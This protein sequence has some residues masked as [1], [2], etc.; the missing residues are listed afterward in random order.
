VR[1]IELV[2]A[3][4]VLIEQQVWVLEVEQEVQQGLPQQGEQQ[5]GEQLILEGEQQAHKHLEQTVEHNNQFLQQQVQH[6]CSLALLCSWWLEQFV[7]LIHHTV[8]WQL[9]IQQVKD[10]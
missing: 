8:P 5:Q 10:W 6:M 1:H 3:Q 7:L 2:Q 9:P 4:Q